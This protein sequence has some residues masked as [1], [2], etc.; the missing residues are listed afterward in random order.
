MVH[1]HKVRWSV[2]LAILAVGEVSDYYETNIVLGVCHFCFPRAFSFE[3]KPYF[4]STVFLCCTYQFVCI[5]QNLGSRELDIILHLFC[6]C[7]RMG[8]R[9]IKD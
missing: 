3:G 7:N 6:I 2:D 8:P 1:C 4:I 5:C 9:A